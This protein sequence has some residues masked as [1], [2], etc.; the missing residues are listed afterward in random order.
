[1]SEEKKEEEKKDPAC[2]WPPKGAVT[3]SKLTPYSEITLD[4][5]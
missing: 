4:E 3:Q 5:S 1:M 2:T